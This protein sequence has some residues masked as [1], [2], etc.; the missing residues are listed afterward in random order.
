M[1]LY[2][3]DSSALA[4]RYLSEVGSAW[5]DRLTDPASGEV[6]VVAEITRVEVAA[7]IAGQARA[8]TITSSE[9]NAL[10]GLLLNHCETKYQ[11]VALDVAMVR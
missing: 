4:K 7:A 6:I 9:R 8:A 5:I 1:S 11:M 3:F 10:V 2:F